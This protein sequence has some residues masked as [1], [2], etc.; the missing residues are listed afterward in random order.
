MPNNTHMTGSLPAGGTMNPPSSAA[1]VDTAK[2]IICRQILA[3]P[4]PVDQRRRIETLAARGWLQL[5]VAETLLAQPN[6]AEDSHA[7]QILAFMRGEGR[8]KRPPREPHASTPTPPTPASG[9]RDTQL[10]PKRAQAWAAATITQC[11]QTVAHAPL[12][13]RDDTL[14][15]QLLRAY[16]VALLAGSVDPGLYPALNEQILQQFTAATESNGYERDHPGKT[17][18]KLSRLYADAQRLGPADPPIARPHPQQEPT[19]TDP[20]QPTHSFIDKDGLL[21][22]QLAEA[23]AARLDLGY[24]ALDGRFH[25]YEGG[26]Y[27]QDTGQIEREVTRLLGDRFRNAHCANATTMLRHLDGTRPV[28]RDPQPDH[29]NVRNGMINWRTGELEPHSP[30]YGSTIQLPVTYDPDATCPQFEQFIQQVLPEDCVEQFVWELI[31]YL[32]YA[33]NPLHIAILMYGKGRNGKGTLL[34]LLDKLLGTQNI[35][36]ATLHELTENRLSV[37]TL[38]GKLA[39]LAGD[40]DSKYL[41]NTAVFKAITGGDPMQ[42]EYKYGAAFEFTPFAVPVYS[43][44]KAFGSAD[45]SEGWSSRWV[46]IPFPHVFAGREDRT[47]DSRLQTDEEL[48][49]VLARAVAALPALMA[50]GRFDLPDSV[51]EAKQGF[52]ESSDTV[53]SWLWDT[54]EPDPEGFVS[55]KDLRDSYTRHCLRSGDRPVSSQN[56]YNRIEQVGGISP[57]KRHG[58]RGFVGLRVINA[59]APAAGGRGSLGQLGAENALVNTPTRPYRGK[60]GETA[61]FAPQSDPSGDSGSL[62]GADAE[63]AVGQL[64]GGDPW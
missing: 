3:T 33:G 41:D 54:Y 20:Q 44:N 2:G 51:I 37:A 10:T 57:H 5:V 56:L 11:A 19:M 40:L 21:V 53:R 4:N 7:L 16:R 13:T 22:R 29:I 42:G 64:F 45:S 23:I 32:L 49:G 24:C 12:H 63:N 61:P 36:T 58:E 18:E 35:S 15:S 34:R 59:Y 62:T 55:R 52:V 43:T 28:S 48:S 17:D 14:N 46:V 25:V 26:V 60:G 27:R 8:R 1:A 9:P 31:G 6:P 30:D 38:F 47:L 50:R 39:N